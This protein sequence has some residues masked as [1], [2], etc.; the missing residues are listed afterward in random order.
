[1][2]GSEPRPRR[3]GSRSRDEQGAQDRHD[4]AQEGRESR[5]GGRRVPGDRGAGLSD[6]A[7]LG[8]GGRGQPEDGGDVG[9]ED[10]GCSRCAEYA[11]GT[12]CV[13]VRAAGRAGTTTSTTAGPVLDGRSDGEVGGYAVRSLIP[14]I[15]NISGLQI[16]G[17][18]GASLF[19][20]AIF[21]WPGVGL[22]MFNAILGRDVPVIQAVLLVSAGGFTDP[23]PRTP[24]AHA[25][26]RWR[27]SCAPRCVRRRVTV[28]SV[29]LSRLAERRRPDA[30]LE[31]ELP[32]AGEALY[33]RDEPRQE[34]APGFERRSGLS[35]A[36]PE[37][38][39]RRRLVSDI[40]PH[41]PRPPLSPCGSPLTCGRSPGAIRHRK[42][43][44]K[45]RPGGSKLPPGPPTR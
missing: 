32:A 2:S 40:H 20:E 19:A 5:A 39:P 18:F 44:P 17:I 43:D 45:K 8:T 38:A 42:P 4:A 16:G 1:M 13:A 15:V 7:V 24:P 23:S 27:P 30:V 36:V 35:D 28:A 31:E 22:L 21:Q 34:P 12:G 26:G 37:V 10:G 9:R 33:R 3:A 6:R 25:G 11:A 41:G 14:A 29:R